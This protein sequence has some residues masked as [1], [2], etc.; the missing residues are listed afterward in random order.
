[1]KKIQI[2]F[3]VIIILPI[4]LKKK[5]DFRKFAHVTYYTNVP[6][7]SPG[8]ALAAPELKIK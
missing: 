4:F 2:H 1:M 8:A 7:L 5:F 3:S 6:R